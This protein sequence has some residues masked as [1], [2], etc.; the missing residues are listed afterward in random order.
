MLDDPLRYGLLAGLAI[1]LLAAAITDIRSRRISNRLARYRSWFP[2]PRRSPSG[3]GPIMGRTR[4][5]RCSGLA[6][7]ARQRRLSGAW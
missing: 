7:G 4:S 3:S 1:A 2:L 5:T 6:A